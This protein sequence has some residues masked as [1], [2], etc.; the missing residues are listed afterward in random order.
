[1]S[2]KVFEALKWASLFLKE[3]GRDE[4]GGEI[5][6]CH[7][8][9]TDRTHMLASL[10][11]YLTKEIWEAFRQ[12][13]IR[14]GDGEPIQYIMGYEHFYGRTFF[15]NNH[16][17]IPRPETEELVYYTL[18]R[19]EKWFEKETSLNVL[20]VGTGSGAIAITLKLE[21][22][23]F[24][25]TGSDISEG[26]ISVARKNAHHLGA[27][28]TFIQGDLL[29]P[30]M[31]KNEKFHVVVSNPPYIPVVDKEKLSVVVKNYEPHGA[32]F[33]GE[34]GLD[35]YRELAAQLPFVLKERA[36]VSFE[37]GEGQG[38]AVRE[39]LQKSFPTG[40]VELVKDINGKTRIVFLFV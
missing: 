21:K 37:I 27:D 30:F 1:M 3:K 35:V 14:H 19:M 9:K 5:L 12:A 10:Q 7:Y 40:K 17:L 28:V 8:L 33:A 26:A 11:D 15:V 25:V 23:S 22:P 6:L 18:Q 16:V 2:K 13:V 36:M 38:D 24:M 31:K 20:D 34:D 29:K 32:L 4:N 39:I